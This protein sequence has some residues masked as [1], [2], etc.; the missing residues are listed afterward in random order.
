MGCS[1]IEVL[2]A[3]NER[4]DMLSDVN[5]GTDA[6]GLDPFPMIPFTFFYIALPPSRFS[7]DTSASLPELNG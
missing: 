7:A 6:L 3:C 1:Y 2:V 4:L 5:V